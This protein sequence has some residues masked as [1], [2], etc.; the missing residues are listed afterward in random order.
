MSRRVGLTANAP[1]L[2][3]TVGNRPR[4]VNP[5]VAD[6][7]PPMSTDDEDDTISEGTAQAA[8]AS[9]RAASPKRIVPT[10]RPSPSDS[11]SEFSAADRSRRAAIQPTSFAPKKPPAAEIVKKR[12]KV[13]PEYLERERPKAQ[14]KLKPGNHLRN[15]WGFTGNKVS[16]ST[17][18]KQPRSSQSSQ[19]GSSQGSNTLRVFSSLESPQKKKPSKF[20]VPGKNILSSPLSSPR[21]LFTDLNGNAD[22]DDEDSILAPLKSKRG[23]KKVIKKSK[24]NKSPPSSPPRAVFKLPE[25][26]LDKSPSE[27]IPLGDAADMSKLSDDEDSQD[28]AGSRPRFKVPDDLPAPPPAAKCPWCGEEVD[29]AQLD[30]FGQGKR[31]TVRLQTRFCQLH[32]Q[33]AAAQTWR[34]RGYPTIDWDAIEARFAVHSDHLRAVVDG[35]AAARSHF[36]TLHARNIEA[37]RARAMKQE[38]NFNPGYYGPR[39]LSAMGD[40]LV[41]AFGDALKKRA[42]DD[43]VVAGR[44]SAAFIQAVLVPELGVRLIMEDLKLSEAAARQVLEESKA[45]GELVQPEVER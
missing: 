1:G 5:P 30:E 9:D 45:L 37:G 10:R 29:R 34:D 40:Y 25:N 22:S 3:K 27:R 44:G 23:A 11:D 20:I 32:K 35:A 4:Q 36:R 42:V 24:K 18:G 2:L 21:K 33:R 16:K 39:G 43:R 12:K 15:K 14:D 7:A 41:S 38:E 6:D 28:D 8:K 19:P 26:F 13:S 17:Y 31:L